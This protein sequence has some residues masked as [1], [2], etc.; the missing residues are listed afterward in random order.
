MLDPL[1]IFGEM[2]IPILISNLATLIGFLL[3]TAFAIGY[4]RRFYEGRPTPKSWTFIIAGL[5]AISIAEVGEFLSP[6]LLPSISFE[7]IKFSIQDL[8]IILIHSI[9]LSAQTIGV[10][11][12]AGGCF[13]L[14]REIV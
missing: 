11:L 6:Y 3:A 13:F 10:I 12:I 5:I 9:V 14:S 7:L 1:T 4:T 8:T 2:S